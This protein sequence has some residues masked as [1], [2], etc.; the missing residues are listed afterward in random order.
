M[1]VSAI[2]P[3][4]HWTYRVWSSLVYMK[5]GDL[6]LNL[7]MDGFLHSKE[8]NAFQDYSRSTLLHIIVFGSHP[9]FLSEIETARSYLQRRVVCTFN[10]LQD[11]WVR[12]FPHR[13]YLSL[14]WALLFIILFFLLQRS[15]SYWNFITIRSN[16]TK[17]HYK[18][19]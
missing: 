15:K 16:N 17:P 6:S 12:A 13:Y 9:R 8:T 10:Q 14:F 11:W 19:C 5:E 3:F 18:V 2:I 1:H 7:A 4:I